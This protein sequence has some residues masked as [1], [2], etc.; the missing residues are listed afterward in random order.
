MSEDYLLG[1]VGSGYVTIGAYLPRHVGR[2]CLHC[3]RVNVLHLVRSFGDVAAC[4][5]VRGFTVMCDCGACG[6]FSETCVGAVSG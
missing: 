5:R 3:D 2:S 1:Y 6:P 4:K